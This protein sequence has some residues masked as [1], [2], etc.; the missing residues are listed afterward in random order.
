MPAKNETVLT[1]TFRYHWSRGSP[2]RLWLVIFTGAVYKLNDWL[3]DWYHATLAFQ[4]ASAFKCSLQTAI[5]VCGKFCCVEITAVRVH[6]VK[7]TCRQRSVVY[8]SIVFRRVDVGPER[9]YKR[10]WRRGY[11]Q[12][13][14]SVLIIDGGTER[15]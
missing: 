5:T 1:V 15:D 10:S 14:R 4:F 11:R 6:C 7:F 9:S 13:T 12:R 3:I 8:S 2:R